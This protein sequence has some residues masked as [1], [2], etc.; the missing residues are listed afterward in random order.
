MPSCRSVEHEAAKNDHDQSQ[1]C[2]A[3]WLSA[4]FGKQ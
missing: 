2:L 4:G 3:L 1:R